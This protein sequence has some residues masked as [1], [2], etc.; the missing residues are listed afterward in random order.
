MNYQNLKCSELKDLL[1]K[2]GLPSHGKKNELLERLLNYEKENPH[3]VSSPYILN[4]GSTKGNSE[5]GTNLEASSSTDAQGGNANNAEANV[6]KSEKDNNHIEGGSHVG[7]EEEENINYKSSS[8]PY[9]GSQKKKKV[10]SVNNREEDFKRADIGKMKN[11]FK[12]ILTSNANDE[13]SKYHKNDEKADANENLSQNNDQDKK[14]KMVIPKITF[15]ETSLSTKNTLQKNIL[16]APGSQYRLARRGDSTKTSKQDN[17]YLTEEKKRE[18][19]KKRFGFVSKDEVLES[20]AKRFCIVTK[21][22]E[23]ENKRK[24]AERFGLK[25]DTLNDSQMKRKRAERF[26]LVQDSDKMKARALRFGIK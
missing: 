11:Y 4:S 20:R 22:M 8:S 21:K 13:G 23:E 7:S 1:A 15:S 12:N 18:L 9:I 6:D 26:G 17:L 24:R 25:N 3:L 16:S 19:R 10:L 2:R 14:T 5:Q